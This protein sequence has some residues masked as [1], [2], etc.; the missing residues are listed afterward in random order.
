MVASENEGLRVKV[1]AA[2]HRWQDEMEV[3]VEEIFGRMPPEE[4]FDVRIFTIFVAH[5]GWLSNDLLG[6]RRLTNDEYYDFLRHL[7]A[8]TPPPGS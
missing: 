1:T 5:H 3:I 2:L 4:R 7:L 8:H 6:E